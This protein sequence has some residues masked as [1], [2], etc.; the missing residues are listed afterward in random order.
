MSRGAKAAFTVSPY[1]NLEGQAADGAL[2]IEASGRDRPGL[3]HDLARA[4]T[5]LGFSIQAARI[6]GYGER[7]VDVFYVTEQGE[8]I[9]DPQKEKQIATALMRVLGPGEVDSSGA[10]E[11]QRA[12]SSIGR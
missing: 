11:R 12:E 9:C 10:P 1:V 2:V 5:D 4:I 7:A 8:K 6:D 3:L